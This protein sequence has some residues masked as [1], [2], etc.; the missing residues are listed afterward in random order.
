L[1]VNGPAAMALEAMRRVA[2]RTR[3]RV[4][5]GDTRNDGI[6]TSLF[7]YCRV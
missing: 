5:R 1:T 4:A 2:K 7:F 6:R 3:E